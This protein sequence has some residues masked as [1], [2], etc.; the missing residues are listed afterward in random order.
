MIFSASATLILTLILTKIDNMAS[1][2]S[3]LGV[4]YLQLSFTKESFLRVLSLWGEYGTDLFLKTIWIDYIYP[5]VYSFLISGALAITEFKLSQSGTV[6]SPFSRNIYLLPFFAAAF[7]MAENS[8]H[9]YIISGKFFSENLIFTASI[10]A[11]VKWLII[12]ISLAVFMKRYFA[13]RKIMKG[14]AR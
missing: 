8:L 1:G 7:D 12:I 5:V 6:F 14:Q 4:F 10:A 9:I 2:A 13:F 11:S 3:G